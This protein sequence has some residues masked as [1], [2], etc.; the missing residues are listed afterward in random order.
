[1]CQG[2]S[3][4]KLNASAPKQCKKLLVMT[5]SLESAI[6][7]QASL[8]G[9]KKFKNQLLMSA[10]GESETEPDYEQAVLGGLSTLNLN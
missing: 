1:M 5:E 2:L 7:D 6:Q 4:L 9:L 3:S 8:N 10:K